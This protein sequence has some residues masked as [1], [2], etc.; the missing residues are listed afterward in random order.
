MNHW[1]QTNFNVKSSELIHKIWMWTWSARE[2]KTHTEKF[3]E[4]NQMGVDQQVHRAAALKQT[5][6]A[7]KTGRHCS[8]GA[9]D[10]IQLW[11]R[12]ISSGKYE[13]SFP[14]RKFWSK[15]QIFLSIN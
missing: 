12:K 9:I 5:N 10:K 15:E 8:R 6:K 1:L 3:Y 13:L 14:M 2:Y 4:I 7:Y 11:K